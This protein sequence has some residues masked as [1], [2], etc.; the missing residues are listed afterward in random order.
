MNENC[1]VYSFGLI[2]Y[3]YNTVCMYSIKPTE[4]HASVATCDK[5]FISIFVIFIPFA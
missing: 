5:L 1:S 3:K 4:I 2:T